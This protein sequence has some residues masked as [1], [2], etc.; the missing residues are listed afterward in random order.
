MN[1][2]FNSFKVIIKYKK[3]KKFYRKHFLKNDSFF[4]RY[5]C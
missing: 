4:R 2:Y 1:F 3:M 5:Y